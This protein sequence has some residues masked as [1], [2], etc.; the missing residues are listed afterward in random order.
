MAVAIDTIIAIATLLK[1]PL[2]VFS[3]ATFYALE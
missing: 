1:K 2:T 3:I